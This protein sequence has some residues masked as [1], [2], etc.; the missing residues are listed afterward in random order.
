MAEGEGPNGSDTSGSQPPGAE[1]GPDEGQ[2]QTFLIA[3]IRGYTFF[4]QEHGDEAAGQL[5]SRF[6]AVT[7][8]VIEAGGGIVLELRGDE[9]LCTFSTTRRAIRAAIELQARL[10]TETLSDPTLP[11]PV[12]IGID[13]GEAVAVAGGFRGRALN[14]AARL[15]GSARAGEILASREAIHMAGR[16]DGIRVEDRGYASFKGIPEP[17]G[18]IRVSGD[19]EDPARWFADHVTSGP[20]PTRWSSRRRL[21][22]A[23]LATV[24]VAAIT[25]PLIR[26]VGSD[27]TSIEPNSVGILDPQTGEVTATIGFPTRPGHRRG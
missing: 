18:V 16:M 27:P 5:A 13:T 20:P 12:G 9:A 22:I 23:A 26:T 6:A 15:C 24:L 8:Q 2:I 14:L 19:G 11:L 21:G 3:D 7:T 4:S 10:R 1:G 25:I 17:V